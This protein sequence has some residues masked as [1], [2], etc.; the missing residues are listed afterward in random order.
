MDYEEYARLCLDPVRLAA[1]G[2]SA[3]GT[4]TPEALTEVTG[5]S[6]RKA[7]E[8]IAGLRLSGLTDENDRLV[9]RVLREIAGT[10]PQAEAAAATITD[11]SWTAGEVK[12]LETFFSGEELVEIP[13]NRRKRLVVLERLAQDFEPGI[14]Y[15]EAEVSRHLE[16]YHPDYAALRRYLVEESLMTR[17]EGTYWRTGGRFQE[18]SL[19]ELDQPEGDLPVIS[20]RGPLLATVREGVTLEPYTATHRRLLLRAADDERIGMYMS[21][22]FPFPYRAEDADSW[23]AKCVAEEPPLNFGVFV[24]D[25]LVGGVGCEPKS[26]ILSGSAEMGW[27]LT[28]SW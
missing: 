21:N 25:E 17:A 28:P 26:D 15:S 18:E 24:G 20:A 3:E 4:L 2:R 10:V 16:H 7:L 8:T 22:E 1:L 23:I 9:G 5:V 12:V 19:F 13:G 27:W 6:R 14:K 11:G